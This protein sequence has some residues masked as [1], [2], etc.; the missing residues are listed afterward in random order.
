LE[1]VKCFDCGYQSEAKFKEWDEESPYGCC[2]KC[3]ADFIPSTIDVIDI[4]KSMS[5]K[6]DVDGAIY[7]ICPVCKTEIYCEDWHNNWVDH[8]K[9]CFIGDVIRGNV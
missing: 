1:S 5:V 7:F 6:K 9:G 8:D 4:L 2:P 3:G